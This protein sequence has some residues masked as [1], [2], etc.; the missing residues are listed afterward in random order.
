MAN[1]DQLDLL[2]QGSDVWNTWRNQHASLQPDLSGAN[3]TRAYLKYVHLIKAN[4][5]GANLTRAHLKEADLSQADLSGADLSNTKLNEE[6]RITQEQ[7]GQAK[8][9]RTL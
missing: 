2:K 4:L 9:G 3:L 5:S 8:P 6:T 7:I 1:Q